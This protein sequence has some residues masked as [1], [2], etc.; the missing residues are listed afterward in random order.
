MINRIYKYPVIQ[1]YNTRKMT[2]ALTKTR[3]RTVKKKTVENEIINEIKTLL[4]KRFEEEDLVK[5]NLL[6]EALQEYRK[7]IAEYN[8]IIGDFIEEED[9]LYREETEAFQMTAKTYEE[10]IKAYLR[11]HNEDNV[12]TATT[13]GAVGVKLPKIC[14]QPFDGE[15][16]KW[17]TFIEQFEATVDIK[18]DLSDIEKFTYLKGYLR[19]SALE[20]I[21]G[22]TLTSDNYVQA[23]ELLKRRFGNS[24][25][26]ISSH[27]NNLISLNKI[28]NRNV[29]ELRILYDKI[30]GNVRALNSLGINSNNFGP[31]LIPIILEKL[32]NV[33]RLQVSRKLGVGNWKIEEFMGS[34]NEE[35]R[36][37]NYDLLTVDEED[38]RENRSRL[39]KYTKPV[40]TGL[41]TINNR[42]VKCVFCKGDHYSDKCSY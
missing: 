12:S 4:N 34:I 30:E 35:L 17:R 26:I 7:V 21:N 19:D 13:S 5:A 39:N 31:L 41:L 15:A 1:I 38:K 24:Q 25:L 18:D 6:L 9:E 23:K 22:L 16:L 8:D 40:M 27:M 29:K 42:L 2:T 28:I 32:P 11:R 10:N 14:I 20:A 37:E 33:I 3:R 36:R